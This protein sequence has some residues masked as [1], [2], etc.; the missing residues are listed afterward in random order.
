MPRDILTWALP[1]CF[2]T[3]ILTLVFCAMVLGMAA[4]LIQV[5]RRSARALA[6]ASDVATA[7]PDPNAT[8]SRWA[9]AAYGLWTGGE[10][11][12]LWPPQRARDALES[13]YGARDRTSFLATVDDLVAGQTG[14]VAWD[15]VRALDLLRIGTAAG[16]VS[17]DE[18]WTRARAI[19]A[20]L[21][22]AHGT[23]E[24]LGQA[25]EIGMLAWHDR[26]G[27]TDSTQRERVKRNLPTLRA[28][29]WP[30]IPFG[31]PL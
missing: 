13:W 8:A 7:P 29:L 12:G 26:R 18:C 2:A 30:A 20:S 31:S 9:Q 22:R 27:V 16:F 10:D 21:R 6:L 24:E 11:C 15:Q 1:L 23:W 3:L 28:H 14:N 25:F 5:R 4:S 17:P 19:A